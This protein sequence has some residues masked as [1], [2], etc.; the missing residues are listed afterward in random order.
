MSA[1][2][3]YPHVFQPL[4]I[5]GKRLRNRI[6]FG[7]HT[8]NMSEEGLP[9]ARH[10]GYYRARA[11]GGAA[12]IVVEPI[13]VHATAVLARGNFRHSSDQVIPGFRAITDAGHAADTV[14]IHQL[15]HVG[16]H[17]DADNSF[18]P[19]WSPSGLPSYLDADGS[20]TMSEAEIE[21]V[22]EGFVQAAR[23][24]RACG[25]DGV[26]IYAAYHALL[27]QFWTPWSN[28]REDRWGG[29]FENRMRLSATVLERVR[30][31]AGQDF[32]VGLAVNLHPEVAVSLSVEAM[33]EIIAW[34]DARGLID[35]VTCG[36]GSYFDSTKLIPTSPFAANLG[37]PFARALK[38]VA[39]HAKVQCE[40][41]IR[42]PANAEAI[43]AAGDADL[44]SLVRA[45]IA[46]PQLVDKA[47]AGRPEEIR[48]CISC[49]Q[50]CIARR[51]RDYWISC[52][53]N[54]AAGREFEWG[55]E[56]PA[57]AAQPLR[58]LVIG[59]GP[60]GLE[61]AR[62]A[63]LR[64]HRVTLA[65]RG[66]RLGGQW[67]LAALQPTRHQVGE[68]LAWYETQLRLLQVELRLDCAMT[69]ATVAAGDWD[70]VVVA[71]GSTAD[72][73][74]F[75]RALPAQ[76]A[77]PGATLDSVMT[78]RQVLGGERSPGPRVLLLDDGNA[79]PGLGTALWLAERG[80][81]VTIMTAQ[82]EV[83]KALEATRVVKPLRRS[84]A[85]AGGREL[86]EVALETWVTAAEGATAHFLG[87]LDGRRFTEDFDSLVLATTARA[88]AGLAAALTEAGIA[89]Q[90]IGDCVAPRR[91]SLA[92]LEGRRVGL[93]L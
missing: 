41:H 54:P 27:D 85:A 39:R 80:H 5:R 73:A 24:A 33:Q 55:S 90:A 42:T 6:V 14:M 91:A 59:G 9:G 19:N 15:Y 26:E 2:T 89:H 46:D 1:P 38:A 21:S 11:E 50:L 60:A 23:R 64:G 69:A 43:L 75:Q 8:A 83:M 7:A 31:V 62:I 93:A 70:R 16:Q 66:P 32:I 29:S 82:G 35:Y 81:R 76:D 65:E 40:S 28:R 57:P 48:P 61:A 10:L 44:C 22:I 58:V 18:Q 4:E 63:A 49:N 12:M 87:L 47:A 30:Q 51:K 78:L 71:I 56:P 86:T 34:H 25:F 36:T 68:H 37:Q 84:F 17:G 77:L 52:L 3:L 20:H 92:F 88:D 67:A 53:V 74:G 72:R 13:P 45:Q 79:W